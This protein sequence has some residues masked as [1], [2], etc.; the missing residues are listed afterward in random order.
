ML[1][2]KVHP[3]VVSKTITLLES[4]FLYF[5]MFF[6]VNPLV[7]SPVNIKSNTLG[8]RGNSLISILAKR[9][10]EGQSRVTSGTIR[11]VF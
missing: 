2:S 3:I 10:A 6:V 8:A 11:Y 5:I 4:S 9:E 1:V 7:I